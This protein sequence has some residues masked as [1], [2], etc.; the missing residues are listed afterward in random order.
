MSEFKRKNLYFI[1]FPVYLLVYFAI[2][3]VLSK[4]K[5]WAS[6]SFNVLPSVIVY[7]LST[8]ILS[9]LLFARVRL[10]VGLPPMRLRRAICALLALVFW[11]LMLFQ[12]DDA[13]MLLLLFVQCG[14][15]FALAL[16]KKQ[17]DE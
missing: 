17:E 8:I 2:S 12:W 6:I 1:L 16:R 15:D 7:Y 3:F 10:G 14:L 5:A 4:L 11:I 13:P 9:C